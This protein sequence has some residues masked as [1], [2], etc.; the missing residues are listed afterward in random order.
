MESLYQVLV[1]PIGSTLLL[2]K[3][4][5]FVFLLFCFAEMSVKYGVVDKRDR[6]IGQF[7][8]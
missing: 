3:D 1:R 6:D 7:V 4:L 2:W 8:F 5:L